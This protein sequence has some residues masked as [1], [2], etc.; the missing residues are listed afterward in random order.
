MAGE[1]QD[2]ALEIKHQG[3]GIISWTT[4]GQLALESR[5]KATTGFKAYDYDHSELVTYFKDVLKSSEK[6]F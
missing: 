1:G 3:K 5:I 4:R 2:D 6:F